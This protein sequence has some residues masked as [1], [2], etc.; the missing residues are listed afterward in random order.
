[1]RLLKSLHRDRVT[2]SLLT[3]VSVVALG[4]LGGIAVPNTTHA[5]ECTNA[6]AVGTLPDD[7]SF[8]GALAC[9]LN[10]QTTGEDAV[11]IGDT[12]RASDEFAIAVGPSSEATGEGSIAIGAGADAEAEDAI[13]LGR[14]SEAN[15]DTTIAIS[16]FT[17]ATA[18]R[19]TAI[20]TLARATAS[21]AIAIGSG[22]SFLS[23]ARATGTRSSAIGGG[24]GIFFE[25]GAQAMGSDSVAIGNDTL[26]TGTSSVALGKTANATADNNIAIGNRTDATFIGAIAIG[27][28][29]SADTDLDG[30]QATAVNT[31]AVGA[32]AEALEDNASAYGSGASA[33]GGSST[34]ALG[35]LSAASADNA[36]A[37]G[38]SSQATGEDSVALGTGANASAN[39]TTALGSDAVAS[40][41]NA[42]AI[43]GTATAAG[44]NSTA[45]GGIFATAS[46]GSATAIGAGAIASGANSTAL[47]RLTEASGTSSFAAGIN[48]IASS[49]RSAA[50]G[51][52]AEASGSRALAIGEL[53][54]ATHSFSVALGRQAVSN[55]TNNI[56]IGSSAANYTLAGLGAVVP[57]GETYLVT[58]DTN[59]NLS[60]V[61]TGS[62]AAL[63]VSDDSGAKSL[64]IESRAIQSVD[65]SITAKSFAEEP[66]DMDAQIATLFEMVE[67]AAQERAELLARIDELEQQLA[68]SESAR[69][70]VLPSS[71]NIIPIN[72]VTVANLELAGI[73]SSQATELV[74][75]NEQMELEALALRDTATREGWLVSD[76][77]Y[78]DSTRLMTTENPVRLALDDE[79]YQQYLQD[80]YQPWQV[81]V[82]SVLAGSTAAHGGLQVGDVI[83]RYAGAN[84]FSS[85]EL[86]MASA[87]GSRDELIEVTILR[88]GEVMQL[89]IDGG[90]LGIRAID[91]AES[92]ALAAPGTGGRMI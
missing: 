53:A 40:A 2:T 6:G 54:M 35:A 64:A 4:I 85:Q 86:Q 8:A 88:N 1:M 71:T 38:I 56:S 19:A 92:T 63:L 68:Q 36:T 89:Y 14:L 32:D 59:G 55:G 26:A 79:E 90:P 84:V 16:M 73:D 87:S 18:V 5:F 74:S 27:G 30:A 3:I 28:D 61:S 81:V 91:S 47:G 46:G 25:T 33:A 22:D 23:P 57:P 24:R 62:G 10:A 17:D 70:L 34:T 78:T 52:F 48:S 51:A 43:G 12:A 13:A 29:T 72:T 75:L 41:M 66:A 77:Y 60:A 69:L 7:G 49:T 9:G 21:E 44:T 80:T 67:T 82:E 65:D 76:K 39:I 42:T 83:Q 45:I 20:G 31:T 50:I 58:V 15:F 37:V 11:A